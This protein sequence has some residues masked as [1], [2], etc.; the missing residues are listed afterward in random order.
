MKKIIVKYSE[1]FQPGT[2][3]ASRVSW[4]NPLVKQN[5]EKLFC[6]KKHE[7]LV[8]LEIS[9]EEITAYFKTVR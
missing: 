6:V 2:G 4:D 3:S 9:N 8:G 7:I 1:D 5:M